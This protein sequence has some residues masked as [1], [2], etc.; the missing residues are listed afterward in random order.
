MKKMLGFV[1]LIASL[2]L[3][4]FAVEVIPVNNQGGADQDARFREEYESLSAKFMDLLDAVKQRALQ[5]KDFY[6]TQFLMEHDGPA[7]FKLPGSD[8]VAFIMVLDPKQAA[9]NSTCV[10]G[11]IMASQQFW[12]SAH[13]N[14]DASLNYWYDSYP[15]LNVNYI[16][17]SEDDDGNDTP[18]C[19]SADNNN[20]AMA[21]E[22]MGWGGSPLP[23]CRYGFTALCYAAY[24]GNPNMTQALIKDGAVVDVDC[25]GKYET[26][27]TPLCQASSVNSPVTA[28]VLLA[29][30]STVN[31]ICSQG[32]E[33]TSSAS[34]LCWV[35]SYGDTGLSI[36]YIDLGADVN[37]QCSLYDSM[38]VSGPAICYAA[39]LDNMA[40]VTALL[41]AGANPNV[42]CRDYNPWTPTNYQPICYAERNGD[43][44]M[45]DLL[46]SYGATSCS[47]SN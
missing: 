26:S 13:G 16:P 29:A 15:N 10:A 6:G 33:D 5:W 24:N 45:I 17:S 19:C 32:N 46:K 34:P 3:P 40:V 23:A 4:V 7:S 44:A 28:V 38:K 41:E 36:K 21:N 2:S 9:S 39:I 37:A 27:G 18:L 8:A 47:P 25:R 31:S 30:N 35:I 43:Q 1:C 11:D 14:N 22:I 12:N 42:T 20:T